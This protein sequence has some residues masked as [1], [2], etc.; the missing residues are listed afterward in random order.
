MGFLD[1]AKRTL[2]G[3]PGG[4]GPGAPPPDLSFLKDFSGLNFLRSDTGQFDFL[5]DPSRFDFLK[6]QDLYSELLGAIDDE[7]STILNPLFEGVDRDTN[8][9]LATLTADFADRGL[10]APG[11]SSDIEAIA[12]AQTLGEGARTKAGL[13][14][15]IAQKKFDVLG[16]KAGT[17]FSTNALLAQLISGGDQGF[18]DL[19]SGREELFANLINSRDLARAG[20]LTDIFQG[21]RKETG[22]KKGL[23][24]FVDPKDI[25]KAFAPVPAG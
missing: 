17:D 2:F 14:G 23:F 1:K 11:V 9:A 21:S 6:N 19:I 24:D 3:S 7:S 20:G 13:R 8:S 10:A 4:S 25:A 22:A 5:R 16:Q 18:A 12:K 15:G